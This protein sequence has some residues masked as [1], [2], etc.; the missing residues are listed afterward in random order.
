MQLV[1]R[2]VQN[3]TAYLDDIVV[4]STWEE[5]V[6]TLYEVFFRLAGASANREPDKMW[7]R[8]SL[9]HLS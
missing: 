3:F 1:L 5:H 9:R 6:E 7:I 8:Q 4:L 2:Y